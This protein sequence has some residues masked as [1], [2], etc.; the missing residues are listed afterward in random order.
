[1]DGLGT[2]RAQAAGDGIGTIAQFFDCR[3]NPLAR[4]VTDECRSLS[5][6]QHT[7]YGRLR[8]TGESRHIVHCRAFAFYGSNVDHKAVVLFF[9][10]I[11]QRSK[12]DGSKSLRYSE[13]I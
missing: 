13:Y 4:F 3:E 12:G 6:V 1:G 7:R 2:L 10:A 5:M 9:L 8:N 11:R